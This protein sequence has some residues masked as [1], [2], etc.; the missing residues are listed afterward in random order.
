MAQWN[1]GQSWR[2]RDHARLARIVFSQIFESGKKLSLENVIG[3][4]KKINF[5]YAVAT[6]IYNLSV[7]VFV[8]IFFEKSQRPNQF[9]FQ[10]LLCSQFFFV[11]FVILLKSASFFCSKNFI[12]VAWSFG[13]ILKQETGIVTRNDEKQLTAYWISQVISMKRN[14]I[15]GWRMLPIFWSL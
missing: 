6:N 1:R 13:W 15:R 5:T 7:A 10:L 12:F 3:S 11:F 2:Q 14:Y 4:N 9:Q 8:N